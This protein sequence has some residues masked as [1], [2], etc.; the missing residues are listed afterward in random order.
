[1]NEIYELIGEYIKTVQY[2]EYNLA[3]H[4]QYHITLSVFDESDTVPK[5]VFY[6]AEETAHLIREKL[7]NRTLGQVISYVKSQNVMDNN[8]ITRLEK[9]LDKRNNI[10]HHYFKDLDFEEHNSNLPFIFNQANH[11]TNILSYAENF[12]QHLISMTQELEEQYNN[13]K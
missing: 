9:I 7:S 12:N 5:N 10:I 3:L 2:I 4:I 13:V 1:M 6:S 8:S 11:L